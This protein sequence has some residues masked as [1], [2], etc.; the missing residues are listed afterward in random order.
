MFRNSIIPFH[1]LLKCKHRVK[2]YVEMHGNTPYPNKVVRNV[3]I[4]EYLS[5]LSLNKERA[6]IALHSSGKLPLSRDRMGSQLHA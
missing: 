3:K 5:K 6:L 2:R 4:G 1:L